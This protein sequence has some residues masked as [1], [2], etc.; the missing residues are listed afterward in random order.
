MAEVLKD[1]INGKWDIK[2]PPEHFTWQQPIIPRRKSSVLD[3]I[4]MNEWV[5]NALVRPKRDVA[6]L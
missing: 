6:L 2:T 1:S 3:A 5:S 4:N